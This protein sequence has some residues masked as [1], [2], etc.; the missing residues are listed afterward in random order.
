M[1]HCFLFL[2]GEALW[3]DFNGAPEDQLY[4]P[5]VQDQQDNP[6]IEGESG[7]ADKT[8]EGGEEEE[9]ECLPRLSNDTDTFEAPSAAPMRSD[10]MSAEE[11]EEA[12]DHEGGSDEK[13]KK[14]VKPSKLHPIPM[15]HGQAVGFTG[16]GAAL[17]QN[18][19][20]QH[21]SH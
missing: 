17:R 7:D 6:T 21:V 9:E 12:K 19:T 8:K 16:E 1:M 18:W 3:G 13:E 14:C 2:G 20:I 4:P 11:E 10:V 5:E 15:K